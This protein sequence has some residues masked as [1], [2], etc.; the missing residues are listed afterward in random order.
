MNGTLLGFHSVHVVV[1]LDSLP[2]RISHANP[3][4]FLCAED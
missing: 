2:S 1:A 3:V 4:V